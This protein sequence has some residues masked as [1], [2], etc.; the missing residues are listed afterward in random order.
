MRIVFIFLFIA[1][2]LCRE[3]VVNEL[4]LNTE[5]EV[6]L[7]AFPGYYIPSK[8][9][10]YFKMPVENNDKLEIQFKVFHGPTENFKLD[11]CNYEMRPTDEEVI[12]SYDKC[13]RNV[14][15][16]SISRYDIYDIY[17][18][19]IETY[20]KTK[21]IS[22][23]IESTYA[24]DYL[25]AYVY[26]YKD[27]PIH[28]LYDITYMKEFVLNTTSLKKHEGKYLFRLENEYGNIGS[29]KIK[30]SNKISPEIDIG[31]S[32]YMDKP[33]MTD[34]FDNYLILNHPKLKSVTKEG[35]YSVYEYPYK[36]IDDAGYICVELDIKEKLDYLSIYVGP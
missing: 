17:K 19:P 27:K 3:Y 1:T 36:K 15:Y 16:S 18:F 22:A 2:T 14:K 4:V 25:T 13:F 8:T 9:R 34:D 28:T 32:G 31:V 33:N 35:E 11:I 29:I 21:Y 23:S 24:L 20:E 7:S 26:S 6:A 5:Y 12:N 10:I 30:I